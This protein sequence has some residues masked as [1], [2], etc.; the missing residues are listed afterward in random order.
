MPL[1]HR[2]MP[3]PQLSTIMSKTK[4]KKKK[5]YI[6]SPEEYNAAKNALR[7]RAGRFNGRLALL[8]LGIFAALA[9]VYYILLAMQVLWVTPVLYTLAAS[10]FIVFFFI[11]GGFSREP[12][13]REMLSDTMT[14]AQ[15]DAFI[16]N[17][18]RRKATARKIM[19]VMTPVLLLVMVD[20]FLLFILPVLK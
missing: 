9:L 16:E 15:K 12:V 20:M 19:I 7:D 17:D 10:L 6:A 5:R 13:S 2:L 8:M 3:L 11:N 1:T 18:I 14:D 4:K